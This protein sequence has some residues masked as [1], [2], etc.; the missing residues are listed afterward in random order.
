M[1]NFT[2]AQI[3]KVRADVKWMGD[4]INGKV[5]LSLEDERKALV[6]RLNEIDE[7]LN[8]SVINPLNHEQSK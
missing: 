6:K 1:G 3:E 2:R 5:F 7:I 8:K 4:V